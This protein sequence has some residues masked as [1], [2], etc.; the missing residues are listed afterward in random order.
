MQAE[1]AVLFVHSPGQSPEAGGVFLL[2]PV[3]QF[4]HFRLKSE[5]QSADLTVQEVWRE[6]AQD[7]RDRVAVYGGKK[8]W[9]GKKRLAPTHFG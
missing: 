2:N 8:F 4:L 1:W 5:L 6:M 9:N 3:D 7:L